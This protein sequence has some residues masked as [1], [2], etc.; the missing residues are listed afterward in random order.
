LKHKKSE[1]EEKGESGGQKPTLNPDAITITPS[2]V[3]R[4][5]FSGFASFPEEK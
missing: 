2:T 3:H 1:N 5:V 4:K